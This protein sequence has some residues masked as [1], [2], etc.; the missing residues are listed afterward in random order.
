MHRLLFHFVKI[1]H[2]SPDDNASNEMTTNERNLLNTMVVSQKYFISMSETELGKSFFA[3]EPSLD[4]NAMKIVTFI[5]ITVGTDNTIIVWDHHEDGFPDE[6]Y[7]PYTQ[8]TTEIWG[9]GNVTNG[10]P[11]GFT[12]DILLAG[13]AIVIDNIITLPRGSTIL[14]DGGDKILASNPIAVSRGS[15][16]ETIGTGGN[17][18]SGRVLAGAVEVFESDGWKQEYISPVGQNVFPGD[19]DNPWEYTAIYVMAKD[20]GTQVKLNGGSPVLLNEGQTHVFTS[21]S[22]SDKI[23]SDKPVQVDLVTGDVNANYEQRWYSLRPFADWSNDYYSP[24]GTGA[25][26]SVNLLTKLWFYNPNNFTITIKVDTFVGTSTVSVP[27]KAATYSTCI[28]G[29]SGAHAF[30]TNGDK[31][32]ALTQTDD[33]LNKNQ[34]GSP[35]SRGQLFDWGH[36]LIPSD[37]LTA[38]TVVAVGWGCPEQKDTPGKCTQNDD[39][40]NMVTS[41]VWVTPVNDTIIYVDYDGDGTADK[42]I[43]VKALQG[44]TLIDPNDQDM[45]GARIWSINNKGELVDISMAWGEDPNLNG[46]SN[47]GGYGLDAGTVVFNAGLIDA[48]KS[49]ELEIDLDGDGLVDP[50]DGVVYTIEVQNTSP[51]SLGKDEIKVVDNLPAEVTYVPGTMKSVVKST[52]YSQPIIDNGSFPLAE[53]IY[54]ETT[55]PKNELW[56]ITFNVT[57]NSNATRGTNVIN[58]GNASLLTIDDFSDGFSATFYVENNCQKDEVFPPPAPGCDACRSC[59]IGC[60]AD[61]LKNATACYLTGYTNKGCQC[62]AACYKN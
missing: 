41:V 53:G 9:D 27:P 18:I 50:L 26:C 19:N 17:A 11:P 20:D 59:L 2:L 34:G 1:L 4:P 51:I 25:S 30:S 8:K 44:I 48:R 36:P 61:C 6:D 55:L 14:Y 7:G 12:N 49:W 46:A 22:A 13:D 38:Q 47:S 40:G 62:E 16:P 10:K 32:F 42:T 56:I 39:A 33:E 43:S 45:S 24:V 37:L 57:V 23:T 58:T 54:L 60:N 29:G 5:G 21:V 52:N 35:N 28:P 3:L 31:F 15:Y